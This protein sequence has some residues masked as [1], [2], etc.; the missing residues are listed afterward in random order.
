M[1][2]ALPAWLEALAGA[3]LVGG[4][5]FAVVGSIGLVRLRSFHLRVHGPTKVSTLGVGLVILASM[6]IFSVIG[7]RPVI[8]ELLITV[9]VFMTAPV[10]AQLLMRASLARDPGA[11]PPRPD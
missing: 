5:V 1:T 11:A 6:L 10:S 3:A 4:G 8:H 7:A 9:L 2:E